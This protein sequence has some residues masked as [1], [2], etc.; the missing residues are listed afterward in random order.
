MSKILFVEPD[1]FLAEILQKKLELENHQVHIEPSAKRMVDY[2]KKKVP[3]IIVVD[4]SV[5]AVEVL[6][7]LSEN[8]KFSKI[9][10]VVQAPHMSREEIKQIYDAGAVSIIISTQATPTEIVKQITKHI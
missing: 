6:E 7:N 1:K 8:T 2:L 4:N 5:G 10:V 9:P 3:D